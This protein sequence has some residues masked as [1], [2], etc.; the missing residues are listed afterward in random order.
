[1]R[2]KGNF[3]WKISQ[4]F[5]LTVDGYPLSGCMPL[6]FGFVIRYANLLICSA[7]PLRSYLFADFIK[8]YINK[9][10]LLYIIIIYTIEVMK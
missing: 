8:R 7:K 5:R 10:I 3:H 9:L 6:K 4:R 2:L 1:M